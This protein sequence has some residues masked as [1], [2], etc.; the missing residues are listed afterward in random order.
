MFWSFNHWPLQSNLP[1]DMGASVIERALEQGI[2]FIDTAELYQTYPY[3][4]KAIAKHK[5]VVICSKCYAYTKKD[6][7]ESLANALRSINRDYID[8]FMLHEQE[9]AL[10]IKGHWEAV[11]YLIRA[12]EQGYIR[13]VGISTH[14]IA[15]VVAA[16]GIQEVE[17]IHPIINLAGV[18]IADGS[19]EDM[20]QAISLAHSAGKGI[21]GMKAL[22]GGN[23]LTR[24][25]EALEFVLNIPELAA[26]A[27]GMQSPMEVDYNI[28]YFSG[29]EIPEDLGRQLSRQPRRLHIEE[30]CQGC[31][32]C[33]LKCGA[34][35]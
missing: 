29:A 18:G 32:S 30:W 20:L 6:M 15:G 9:S 4:R 26:V 16:A 1:L 23:L 33:V 27:V 13:A 21:Y 24:T 10:T 11:E 19:T 22:G 34:G 17:V 3:I 8:I 7:M 31:G 5:D 25:E 2:N 12:K 35:A 14:H 28:K